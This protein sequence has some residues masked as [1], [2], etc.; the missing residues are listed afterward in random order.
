MSRLDSLNSM[1]QGTCRT[2]GAFASCDAGASVLPL[3]WTDNYITLEPAEQR[4]LRV[5]YR[6][7]LLQGAAP[8]VEVSGVNVNVLELN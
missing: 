2:I 7:A 5:Q 8:V 3:L 1:P 6:S 4:E